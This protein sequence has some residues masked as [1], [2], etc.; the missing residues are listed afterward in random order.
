M[1]I[2]RLVQGYFIEEESYYQLKWSLIG[3]WLNQGYRMYSE[4]F[5]YTGPLAVIIYKYFDL[6]FGRTM[7]LHYGLSS[8]VIIYQAGIFNMLLLKNKA[9]DENSYLPAFLY[10]IL[11][12]SVPDF[13]ALSPQLLSLTFILLALR[14][15]LRR[16]DNQVTDELFLNSG[17]FIGVATMIY[18][19]SIV[20][21]IV[22]LVSLILFSTAV[23]RRITLY[24]FSFLLVFVLCGLYFYWRGDFLIFLDSYLTQNLLMDEAGALNKWDAV[25]AGAGFTLI[26]LIS[27]FKTWGS[28]R[29]TNF[30]Q[31]IQQ[32]IWLMFFGGIATFFLSNEKSLHE[33]VFMVPIIAYFWTYYFVLLRRQIFK[34]VMPGILIFGLIGYN[35][36]SYRAFL[37]DLIVKPPSTTQENTMIL[38]E[39]LTYYKDQEI[40]TPCLNSTLS[41]RAFEGLEYYSAA[42]RLYQIFNSAQPDLIIDELGVMPQVFERFPKIETQYEARGNGRYARVNN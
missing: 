12:V 3:E 6:L 28:A 26:F 19:P 16:I 42:S 38:G 7:F 1:V 15:V 9:Y 14:N 32:V 21:F 11:M 10:M 20:F 41:T 39:N 2:I 17:I 40:L 4:T 5:D 23:T 22:F 36:Y 25:K 27:I 34:L 8:L 29:Q 35:I 37:N 24:L 13:M 30:Q 33:L 31:K 18:L